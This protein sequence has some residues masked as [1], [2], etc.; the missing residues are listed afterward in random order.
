M[1][2][3][4]NQT[5]LVN[6]ND[7]KQCENGQW[8]FVYK[9][10]FINPNPRG[11]QLISNALQ[12]RTLLPQLVNQNVM[13]VVNE[14]ASSRTENM[15]EAQAVKRKRG[16]PPKNSTQNAASNGLASQAPTRTG[17]RSQTKK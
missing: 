1:L 4:L 17:L 10:E 11:S 7:Q 9:T 13:D 8:L 16:R 14:P 12:S 15:A 3:Y 5:G 6:Y 2:A